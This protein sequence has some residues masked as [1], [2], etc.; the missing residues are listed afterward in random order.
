MSRSSVAPRA[1][2]LASSVFAAA[3]CAL[4]SS[5]EP[6]PFGLRTQLA[7]E[8]VGRG[9]HDQAIELLNGLH[10]ERPDDPEVLGLRGTALRERGMFREAEA[11]LSQA[12]ELVPKDAWTH[13]SLA[14]TLDHLGLAEKAEEHHRKAAE[15]A[16]SHAGYLNNLGFS[17]FVHGKSREAIEIFH[18]ALRLEPTHPRIRNNLG[19]AYARTGD[20]RQAAEQFARGGTPAEAKNNLGFAY[21]VAG[22]LPQAFQL[23]LEATRLDP[24]SERARRNL[25]HLASRMGTPPPAGANGGTAPTREGAQ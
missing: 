2:L 9:H 23:Y 13:S 5:A 6:D 25:E 24:S 18:Q 17:L 12:V 14:L 10:A 15:L 7:R 1:L 22:N 4:T 11:D 8:L 19:F 20:F 21:E 3:A 16:P